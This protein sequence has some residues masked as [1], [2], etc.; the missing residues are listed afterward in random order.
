MVIKMSQS[1]RQENSLALVN[2]SLKSNLLN[3]FPTSM[4]MEL[5]LKRVTSPV[6]E[7][8]KNLLANLNQ[9]QQPGK[10]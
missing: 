8:L 6:L 7:L 2:Q 9:L 5:M 4:E 10:D 1:K 3:C